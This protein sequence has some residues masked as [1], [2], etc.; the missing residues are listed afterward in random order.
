MTHTHHAPQDTLE[1]A[2]GVSP[3]AE[4]TVVRTSA[5]G[6]RTERVTVPVAGH[7]VATYT[8]RPAGGTP[9]GPD[10][11][12][13]LVLSEAHGPHP[14][15]DD[16]ARRFAR[17]GYLA[18]APDLMSRQGDAASYTDLDLLVTEVLQRIPD[19]QVMADLDAV[20]AW[21]AD[22][23]GDRRRAAVNGFSWGGRWAWLYAAHAELA[24]AVSWY[25]VLDDTDSG[26]HPDRA[27][28][29]RHPL[30][31]AGEL[32]TPVLG[33]YAEEDRV[34]PVRTAEAMRAALDARPQGGPEAELV[35]YPG[36]AHGFFADYRD[37]YDPSSAPDAWA[38]ALVWLRRHGA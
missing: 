32:R 21:A 2:H 9:G 18:V 31:L 19:D 22:H 10:L 6:L 34:V 3:A 36:A 14:Y 8:A 26:L 25:G 24:A 7:G 29:P 13:V 5:E 17:Q 16:V 15:I 38:R 11:P 37:E 35:V 28:S 20:L 30:D 4:R 27:L 1:F 12:V 23:G 33:L